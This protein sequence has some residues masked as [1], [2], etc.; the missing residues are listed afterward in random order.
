VSEARWRFTTI[1]H[2]SHRILGPLATSTVEQALTRAAYL[3]DVAGGSSDLVLDVGCGKGELLMRA[4]RHVGGEALGI[5]PNP[6][7]AAAARERAREWGLTAHVTIEECRWQDLPAPP[8]YASL[9]ICTGSAHAFGSLGDALRALHAIVV[10]RGLALVAHGYWKREPAPEYLTAL[11][12]TR[13]EQD[14]WDG[15][16]ARAGAPGWRVRHADASTREEWDDYERA[17][18]A[19]VRAWCAAHPDDPDALAF[20]ERITRW[21]ALVE[22]YGLDTMGYVLLLLQR[23]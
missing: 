17:Y 18:A 7:F 23:D 12:S 5:E 6:A 10:P 19:N 11:G 14:D 1:A 2:A 15:T 21:S 3:R 13:D 8:R 20:M 4:L 9:A 22:Q 16:L